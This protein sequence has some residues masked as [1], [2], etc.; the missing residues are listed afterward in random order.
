MT[1][2]NPALETFLRSIPLF[3]LVAPE[4]MMDILRLLRPVELRAGEPL[5]RQ[6]EPGRAMWVM[7]KGAEVAVSTQPEGQKRSVAVAYAREGD[8]LGEMALIDETPRSANAVVVQGGLAHEVDA[9]EFAAL[10]EAYRPAA[11]KVM[12]KLCVDLCRKLRA[13]NDRLVP[14]GTVSVVTPPLPEGLRPDVAVLEGFAPF[15]PLPA[16]VKLALAQ[17]LRLVVVD[18]LT[19]LFGEGEKTDGAWFLMEG[20]VSVGRG[21]KT[22]ANLLPGTMFGIVSCIDEGTRSASCVTTGAA[23]LLHLADGD[24][25]LLFASGHRF[26][27]QLVD[28]VARQLVSHVRNANAMLAPAGRPIGPAGSPKPVSLKP[29]PPP[30]TPEAA[31][32]EAQE[33]I[34]MIPLE[35][36]LDLAEM[37]LLGSSGELLG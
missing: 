32:E 4:E 30:A 25:D 20:E 10:R 34:E 9:R 26:A 13:T 17:K 3:S 35:L 5:F 27:Y 15:V 28:L 36:E 8:V 12:R 2:A 37:E 7:G 31:A 29:A 18:G 21:G 24:F 33:L 19:P 6:G 16:T 23:R 14:G 11:Y 22:L 1:A